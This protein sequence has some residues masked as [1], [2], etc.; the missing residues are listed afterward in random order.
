MATEVSRTFDRDAAAV[1]VVVEDNYHK[2]SHHTLYVA[3]A[4][5]VADVDAA[6]AQILTD[7][8]TQA[9]LI[10]SRMIAAGWTP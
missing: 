4:S 1:H 7:T 9:A 8:D 5:G 3:G 10:R 2:Q 6:I